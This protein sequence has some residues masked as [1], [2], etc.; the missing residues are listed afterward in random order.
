VGFHLKLLKY[1]FNA[2][3]NKSV[4]C[5]VTLEGIMIELDHIKMV[6]GRPIPANYCD[7][8]VFLSFANFIVGLSRNFQRSLSS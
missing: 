1:Q 7:I 6:T 5:V 8:Q 4:S 2:K 3:H